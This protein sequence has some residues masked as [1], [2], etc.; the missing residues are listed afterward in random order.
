MIT[1]DIKFV[2]GELSNELIDTISAE[3]DITET[4]PRLLIKEALT[5]IKSETYRHIV[6]ERLQKEKVFRPL[7]NCNFRIEISQCIDIIK[8]RVMEGLGQC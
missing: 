8:D 6:I 2:L 1:T 5:Y 4:E 3:M 7:R